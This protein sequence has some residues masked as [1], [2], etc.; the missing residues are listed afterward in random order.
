MVRTSVAPMAH[1]LALGK[2]RDRHDRPVLGLRHLAAQVVGRGDQAREHRCKPGAALDRQWQVG[3]GTQRVNRV[4]GD[5]ALWA[6][7]LLPSDGGFAS[8]VHSYTRSQLL[9]SSWP[10][11][12][13]PRSGGEAAREQADAEVYRP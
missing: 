11:R 8:G 3:Q 1:L 10:S 6:H 5:E 13:G 2:S 7:N 12:P 4:S 9:T